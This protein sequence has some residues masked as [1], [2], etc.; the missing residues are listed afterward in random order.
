MQVHSW[1]DGWWSSHKIRY[2]K[3]QQ[4]LWY[5]RACSGDFSHLKGFKTI[6][7]ENLKN[8]F[9]L[10]FQNSKYFQLKPKL[11]IQYLYWLIENLTRMVL[12]C[13]S[14]LCIVNYI[15]NLWH[16][17]SLTHSLSESLLVIILV[18]THLRFS[19]LK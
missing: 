18:I 17:N 8:W 4:Q 9:F 5:I 2:D 1:C 19:E 11:D 12:I 10:L 3:L 16:R 15:F 13:S 7:K 14:L 6:Y